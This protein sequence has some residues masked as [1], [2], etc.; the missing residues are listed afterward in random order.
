MNGSI[1]RQGGSLTMLCSSSS[2]GPCHRRASTSPR[3]AEA[4]ATA[5]SPSSSGRSLF[6]ASNSLSNCGRK[7]LVSLLRAPT[8]LLN[9]A[10]RLQAK[11]HLLLKGLLEVRHLALEPSHPQAKVSDQS[12]NSSQLQQKRVISWSSLLLI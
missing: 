9:S 2:G 10:S 12:G 7:S 6:L 1:M 3:A 5:D 8:H 11:V 4:E